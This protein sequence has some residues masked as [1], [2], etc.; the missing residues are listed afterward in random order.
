MAT[1]IINLASQFSMAGEV[2]GPW[3]AA[4]VKSLPPPPYTNI[5]DGFKQ[6][7]LFV[8][9]LDGFNTSEEVSYSVRCV[10]WFIFWCTKHK[11]YSDPSKILLKLVKKCVIDAQVMGRFTNV[12]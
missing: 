10:L 12:N 3:D 7:F 9:F 4:D 2:F 11:K 1:T 6:G 5:Y 8:L